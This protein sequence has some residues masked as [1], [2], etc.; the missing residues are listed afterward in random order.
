MSAT[1][2]CILYKEAASMSTGTANAAVEPH[3][4]SKAN[5]VHPLGTQPK[6]IQ[7]RPD[8]IQVDLD[9]V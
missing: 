8:S 9:T 6:Q 4:T 3:I 5:I 2:E 7:N 1:K